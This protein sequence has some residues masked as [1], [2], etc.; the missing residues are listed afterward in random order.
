MQ[1]EIVAVSQDI[2]TLLTVAGPESENV[3]DTTLLLE[4]EKVLLETMDEEL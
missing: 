3:D 1:D 2:D 4:T